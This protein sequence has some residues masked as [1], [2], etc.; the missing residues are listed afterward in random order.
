MFPIYECIHENCQGSIAFEG[1]PSNSY[2]ILARMYPESVIDNLPSNLNLKTKEQILISSQL[3][4]KAQFL[5]IHTKSE[6][7][8][9]LILIEFAKKN[10][11]E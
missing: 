5:P 10:P 2:F 3:K 8:V 7:S 6:Q 4:I 1:W 11:M 9:S